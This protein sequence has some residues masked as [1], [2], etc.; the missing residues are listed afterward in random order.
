M[1]SGT[2]K[3]GMHSHRHVASL[4]LWGAGRGPDLMLHSAY[5]FGFLSSP[6]FTQLS[7]SF[8]M[9][10]WPNDQTIRLHLRPVS[11]T[12]SPSDPYHCYVLVQG[13]CP[14]LHLCLSL[15]CVELGHCHLRSLWLLG[16]TKFDLTIAVS[17]LLQP[18]VYMWL[19]WTWCQSRW[20]SVQMYVSGAS[21]HLIISSPNHQ[22]TLS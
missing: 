4:P 1:T 13:L 14:W 21:F 6:E 11:S 12:P 9:T 8:N 17:W 18:D 16:I 15:N 19:A 20:W 7:R 5:S 2:G 10:T 22:P 3:I